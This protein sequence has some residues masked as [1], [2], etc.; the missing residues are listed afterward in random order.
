MEEWGHANDDLKIE[1]L[2]AGGGTLNDV[3]GVGSP[4]ERFVGEIRPNI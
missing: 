2:L 4:L 3:I 1:E